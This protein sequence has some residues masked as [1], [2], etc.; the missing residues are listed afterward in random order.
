MAAVISLPTAPWGASVGDWTHF[1]LI[2]GLTAD[3]LPV[4]S[5]PKAVK[6]PESKLQGPGKTPSRYNGDRQMVGL[7]K[8]TE[9]AATDAEIE[10]WAREP[11]YGICLQTR[12]VRALDVDVIDAEEANRILDTITEQL[13]RSLPMRYRQ[14]SPKFLLGLTIQGEFTKRRLKTKSGFVEFLANGQQFIACGTHTSG[15]RYE[16]KGGLPNDFPAIDVEAFEALWSLL[17]QTFGT[18]DSVE[19]RKG[20]APSQ[21]REASDADDDMVD[22]LLDHWEVHGTDRRSGR[23]DIRC[24]FESGHST[25]SGESATSYFPAGVGGFEQGHFKCQHASCAH[26]TDG[27]FIEAIGYVAADFGVVELPAPEAGDV[28]FEHFE[29]PKLLHQNRKKSGRIEANRHTV[30]LALRLPQISGVRIARDTFRDEVMVASPKADDWRTFRDEDYYALALKLE[31]G[32]NGFEHVP[33]ELLR[34]AVGYVAAQC[35]FDSAQL[36]LNA[37]QWDGVSRVDTCL[38]RY[39]GADDS[40]YTRAVGRYVWTALAG[41]VL[42][43]GCQADMVPIAVGGQGAR[44]TTAVSMISPS[45]DFFCELDLGMSEDNLARMLRGK[46]VVELGEMKGMGAKAVEHLKATITRRYEEWTPKFKEF[47]TKFARRCLCFGT[48]NTEDN[49]PA[50]P[51]GYRRWLPFVVKD[52]TMCDADGIARDRE[53]LWAEGA[54]MWAIDGVQWRDAERLARGVHTQFEKDDAWLGIIRDW[55]QDSEMGEAAPATR[56]HLALAEVAAGALGI[57][58]SGLN[59]AIERRIGDLLRKLGFRRAVRDERRVWV[60]ATR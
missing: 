42:D 2:L 50:D 5:N 52:D 35:S 12:L 22:F 27:D 18:E 58:T 39:F 23:V 7:T 29:I 16:W 34:D 33:R 8:W 48:T 59:H 4:V 20:V 56:P 32:P 1:S 30:T 37:L 45:P 19:T 57:T 51:S 10:R 9:K 46:L 21:K 28:E 26:R 47:N 24:P 6:S 54:T 53:Q 14:N 44:K 49:L 15:V 25:E 60:N 43:P 41:R 3:L 55:L 13:G 40:E 17:E 11:D 38:H 31:E 36:W